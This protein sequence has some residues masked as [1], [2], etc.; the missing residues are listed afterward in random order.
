[1]SKYRIDDVGEAVVAAPDSFFLRFARPFCRV[2]ARGE[3]AT[4]DAAP[5][6]R[7][8]GRCTLHEKT[9]P[10]T[11]LTQ[12]PSLNGHTGSAPSCW[13]SFCRRCVRGLFAFAYKKGGGGSAAV[14]G[15][16]ETHITKRIDE[17]LKTAVR[18]PHARLRQRPLHQRAAH[19]ADVP[20]RVR[21]F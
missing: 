20:A 1:M 13:P 17:P 2:C 10:I 9:E 14:G 4:S 15:P 5:R 11:N 19:A 18:V 6:A 12:K 16:L 8:N 21:F 3:V 7:A